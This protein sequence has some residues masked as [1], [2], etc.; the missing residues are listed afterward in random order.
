MSALA[1]NAGGVEEQQLQPSPGL[2]SR[3]GELPRM[4]PGTLDLKAPLERG[5][6]PGLKKLNERAKMEVKQSGS[7]ILARWYPSGSYI[8]ETQGGVT[9]EYTFIGGYAYTAPVVA[10]TQGGT[11]TYYNLLRDHLGSITHVVN[12]SNNTL[13]HEYSYDA[14]GRMRNVS[15]WTNYAPGSEPSLFVAGRGFTGHEHL[16]WFN[17]IN[18][19]GRLYDPLVGQF[20]SPDNYIQSPDFT[21]NFNRYSYCLNN[22]LVYA[23]PDGE[24]AWFIPVIIGAIIGGTSGAVMA[25]NAGAEGFWEWAGYI[26]GGAL[27]GGLSGGAAAGVSALGG[28]AM[29]AGATAGAVGGAGFSGMAT[30]WDGSAMLTGAVNGA[31]AGFV[32]GGVGSAIGGGWGALAGGAA[33]NLT[34]QL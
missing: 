33:S 23:D 9:K 14:W 25:D 7:T 15:S 3:A 21:Q 27:V 13:L 19:N 17:L 29:L 20:L 4:L 30:G 2:V 18:M 32:G 26:G 16:P 8:K 11:T 5:R 12:A 28:G 34:S 1:Y 24:L 22:P 31:L 10:I 6:L